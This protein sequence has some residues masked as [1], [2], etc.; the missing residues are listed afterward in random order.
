MMR[1]RKIT[2]VFTTPWIRVSVTMSPLLTWVISCPITASTS[3]R[4]MVCRRP[5]ETATSAEFLNA[6]VAKALGAPSK[7]ATSGSRV[8]A[9]SAAFLPPDTSQN[10]VVPS[11]PSIT[12][13]PVDIFAIGLEMRS[14]MIEPVNPTTAENRSRLERFRP[15]AVR[16]RSSPRTLT[17]I[18][19]TARTATLVSRKRAIRFIGAVILLCRALDRGRRVWFQD[20]PGALLGNDI[21]GRIGVAGGDS[22]EN[23]GIDDAQAPDPVHPQLVVD[24]RHGV[25]AHLARAHRVEDGGSELARRARQFIVVRN[26]WPG[27]EFLRLVLRERSGCHDAPRESHAGHRHAP[28]LL[29]R[30]VVEPDL[31][32]VQR[33]AGPDPDKPSGGGA[34]VAHARR[35]PREG[36]QRI[37]ELVERERLHVPLDVRRGQGWVAFRKGA[38]L[39]RRHGERTG[40]EEEIFEC[41]RSL[42]GE[43]VGDAVQRLHVPNLVLH[44][45]LQVVVQVFADAFERMND[46]NAMPFQ[47]LGCAYPGKLQQLRRADRAGRENGL[48]PCFGKETAFAVSE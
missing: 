22:R 3:S 13:A 16:K 20:G 26:G 42:S 29:G 31:G 10:S 38:R 14:E 1:E 25:P 40:A 12:R 48:A 18:E 43:A 45:D 30:K 46:R 33:V 9:V 32:V 19:M 36:M 44:A 21:G 4:F 27:P 28:V 35:D 47:V 37:A 11:E 23:R 17:M 39:R 5:V 2:K 15:S 6:P 41:H 7:I 34:Q 8:P 24:H